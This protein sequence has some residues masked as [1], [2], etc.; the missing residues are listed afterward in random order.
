MRRKVEEK[1]TTLIKHKIIHRNQIK[2]LTS[3]LKYTNSPLTTPNRS[4]GTAKFIRH[5]VGLTEI[6]HSVTNEKQYV[7]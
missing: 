2:I 5:S 4:D 3:A 1:K 6:K 7:Q